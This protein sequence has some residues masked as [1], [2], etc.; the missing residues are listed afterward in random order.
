M[1]SE[2]LV[3]DMK[4]AMKSG[5]KLR[6]GVIR[7]LRAE[8]KNAQISAGK[9]LSEEEEEKVL[10][11][12]A[13]KRKESVA[14]YLEGSRKDLADKEAAEYDITVSYLPPRMDEK[15]LTTLIMA[16]IEETG[17]ASARDFG[18]VMQ[19]VM[20]TAGSRVDGSIVSGLVKKLLAG[21]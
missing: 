6:L 11:A 9:T 10:S 1:I 15:E 3:A 8:L 5:D 17:A 4:L 20:K 16:K 2:K 13:K 18:A 21:D 12:Y 14:K 7:M 19:A